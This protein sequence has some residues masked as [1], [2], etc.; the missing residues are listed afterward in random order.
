MVCVKPHFVCFMTDFLHKK[1]SFK[2]HNLHQNWGFYTLST[3]NLKKNWTYNT[4]VNT[5]FFQYS[6]L[7]LTFFVQKI[8]RNFHL[9]CHITYYR[10]QWIYYGGLIFSIFLYVCTS[11]GIFI[12]V[13]VMSYFHFHFHTP[14]TLSTTPP[15]SVDSTPI[16]P[17]QY[18]SIF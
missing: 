9:W 6:A 17:S 8:S 2:T 13:I 12:F 14:C 1:L 4:T 15:Y 10:P 7:K 11:D 16:F 3:R 5:L 18:I